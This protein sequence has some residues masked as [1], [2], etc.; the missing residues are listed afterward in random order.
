MGGNVDKNINDGGGPYIFQINGQNHH[1]IR[2]LHRI[3]GSNPRFAQL[4]FYDITNEV[5]YRMS[6]LNH[7]NSNKNIES[8][9]FTTLV[10]MLNEINEL[11]KVFRMVRDRFSKDDIHQLRLRLISSRTTDGRERNLPNYFEIAVIII[12]IVVEYKEGG[13]K[14]INELHPSYMALQ[15]PLLFPYRE[16]G[17]RLV[18]LRR[19]NH[20]KIKSF[21]SKNARQKADDQ[22]DIVIRLSTLLS[23]KEK[24]TSCRYTVFFL[25]YD[26]THPTLIKIDRIIST[27]ILDVNGNK[28]TYDVVKQY[29]VHGPCGFINPKASCMINNKCSKSFP[30]KFC[31]ETS[32]GEDGFAVYRRRD[33]LDMYIENNGLKLDN[34]FFVLYNV[35]L[36]CNRSR[37]IKYLFKYITKGPDR[38][39]VILEENLHIDGSTRSQHVTN[40]DEIKSYLDYRYV[41]ATAAYWK[42]FWFDIHYCELAIER[43]FP[44]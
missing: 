30:K 4:Y 1:K 25:H 27:E 35:D 19:T 31:K 14:R 28:I 29:M 44:S 18:I 32:I 12:D 6:V 41:Y 8:S 22:P 2:T 37:S 40:I 15:Y 24:T 17:F 34:R 5:Q 7:Y 39:T 10:Q 21:L 3:D 43:L 20:K 23:T 42:I 33:D 26:D 11:V 16:D 38:V 36:L 13:L 9:I